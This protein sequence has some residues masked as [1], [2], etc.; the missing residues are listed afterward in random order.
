MRREH[1][2]QLLNFDTETNATGKSADICQLS[3][4]DKSASHKLSVYIMPTQDIDLYAS[5]VNKLKMV[6]INGERKL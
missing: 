5:K 4:T 2:L 6:K 3:V 1:I